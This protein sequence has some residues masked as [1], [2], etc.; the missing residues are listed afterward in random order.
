MIEAH[1]LRK[2]A[3]ERELEQRRK[4]GDPYSRN[5]AG[6]RKR[7]DLDARNRR[8]EGRKQVREW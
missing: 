6:P 3:R 7:K 8:R 2:V 1:E 4:Y 5:A